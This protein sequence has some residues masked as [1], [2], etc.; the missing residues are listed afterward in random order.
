M[1][2]SEPLASQLRPQTIDHF[3]GQ[4]H[5]LAPG[6]PL[7]ESIINKTIH[8]CILW[9]SPGTGKTTL[10]QIMANAADAEIEAVSAVLSGVKDIRAAIARAEQRK[11]AGQKTVLFVDEV[12]RFN[13]SQQ[14]AFL[15]FVE[16]GLVIFIGAT[17]ENPAFEL[18]NALL[19]RASVYQFKPLA[20]E[21]LQ[22][23]ILTALARYKFTIEDPQLLIASSMGD[24]RKCLNYLELAIT[25]AQIHH[26]SHID[27]PLIERV[28]VSEYRAFDKGGDQFYDRISALHKSL[29]GSAPDAALFWAM[30]ML[31]D[32]CSHQYILR[33]L[34]RMASEDIGNA[35]PRAVQI[36]LNAWDSYERLGKEEGELFI[37]QAILYLASAPKSN[38]V[39]MAYK[40]CKMDPRIKNAQ[41]PIHLRNAPTKLAKQMNH[42][43]DYKYPHDYPNAY[44]AGENYFPEGMQA[45]YY[46]PVERGLETK[47]QKKLEFLQGLNL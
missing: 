29:R 45:Q 6:L 7:Y 2:Q 30:S 14:D 34:L 17:T 15:P 24:A 40:Q 31:S 11:A 19:S 16:N 38:A 9:G 33:R 1:S 10:A 18:N 25:Q 4:S 37:A 39:Y 28:L 22:K 8:S 13:K 20:G 35:D 42:G 41:V 32:G 36:V 23:L 43:K 3:L 46:L 5:L 27:N 47:I 44:V 26:Q 21:D 12:H